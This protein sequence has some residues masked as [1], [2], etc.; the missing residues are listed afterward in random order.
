M[1]P[2]VCSNCFSFLFFLKYLLLGCAGSSLPREL[3]SS[4]R[5]C[6]VLSS[7]GAWAPHGSG[8]SRHRAQAPGSVGSA[9]LVPWAL[10][11][12]LNGCCIP[13]WLP[14]ST[15]DLPGSGIEPV[16]PALAGGFFTTE[17]PGKPIFP[18]LDNILS[19]LDLIIAPF[20]L[21]LV[22]CVR[23]SKSVSSSCR[24]CSQ[25]LYLIFY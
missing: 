20:L 12:Q 23:T 5:E 9:V 3:F 17:P 15:W 1:S 7:R 21:C 25:T 2:V 11:H 13:A 22:F 19:S 4:C 24:R 14:H 8:F 6:R 16:S 10:G 18:F